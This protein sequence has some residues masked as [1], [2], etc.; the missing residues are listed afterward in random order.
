MNQWLLDFAYRL[1][2]SWWIFALAAVL[3]LLISLFTIGYRAIR[4]ASAN[5]T[6]SLRAS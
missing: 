5:P 6:D 4:A 3:A 2:I 1:P